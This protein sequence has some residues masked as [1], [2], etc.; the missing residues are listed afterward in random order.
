MIDPQKILRN[1]FL[2]FIFTIVLIILSA[3]FLINDTFGAGL[4]IILSPIP[5]I[6]NVVFLIIIYYTGISKKILL[7]VKWILIETFIYIICYRLV[8]FI[9]DLIENYYSKK[10][11]IKIIKSANGII[12]E[13]NFK[14]K[15]YLKFPFDFIYTFLILTLLIWIFD[16]IINKK[17][18]NI[19]NATI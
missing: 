6:F 7:N 19:E 2:T 14:P 5:S 13:S 18:L 16:K 11:I 4:I 1:S 3:F 9:L 15:F 17:N 8:I 10:N 12:Y